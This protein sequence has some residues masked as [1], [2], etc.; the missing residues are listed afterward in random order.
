[1][2]DSTGQLS[3]T[4]L[5]MSD[6]RTGQTRQPYKG[7]LSSCPCRRTKGK[8]QRQQARDERL[9]QV[10]RYRSALGVMLGGV[11]R[12]SNQGDLRTVGQ[13]DFRTVS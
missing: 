11:S 6:G 7:C 5:D 13:A 8:S 9:E 4:A 2:T 1:M 3:W 12:S 10:Q